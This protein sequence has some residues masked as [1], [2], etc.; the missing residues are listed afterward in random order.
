MKIEK[1]E[2]R[3]IKMELVS[4]FTTSMGTEYDEEHIIVRVD[5]EG[6][7]GWGECVAEGTPFYSYETVTTA[8]HILLDFLIPSILGK[9][10]SSVSEAISSYEKV[11]GHRMAKAGLEAALWDLFAKSKGISL[12]KMFGGKKEK[13]DVGVSIGIQ[14]S[15][16]DLIRKVEAYLVE[17]YKR[18]KIKIAPGND[19]QFVKAVRKEFPDIL[20]QV[21]ANSAYELK[22]INLFKQM[23]DYNLLLI[24]QPLGYDDIFE[25]S[26]LQRE[27][28]TPI[29]LDE[30]IHSL[31]D[32]RAAIELDS[33]RVINIKPGRVGGFSESKLIHDYCA[34][35]NIPV[36]CGGMLE[37]GIGRAGNVALA[38]L[39]NFILPGDIS[40]SKRYYKED[41]VEP[42]FVLN[43]DGT[44]D[45]PV[46]PGIGVE[47]NMKML[48]RVTVKKM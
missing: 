24:E 10:I 48:D 28:E 27:L 37:S 31:A 36:W 40:A 17:G 4:P 22:D 43:K 23:D 19:I 35:E 11:R 1:I 7:T 18:I 14:S 5:S 47:V 13:I 39:P 32:T 44:I 46:K 8:W 6:L 16:Q 21:D 3:H 30:S 15:V 29:C 45:V 33:C 26:K 25:H 42:E 34:S 12:S 41:I 20:L 38:S 9:N 2:L